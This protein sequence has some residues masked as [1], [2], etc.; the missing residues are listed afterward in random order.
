MGRIFAD[1]GYLKTDTSALHG[2][3]LGL[4]VAEA[5]IALSRDI[6]FPTTLAEVD[7][8]TAAHVERC[9]A[10]AKDPRLAVKLANMPVPLSA[11]TVDTYMHPILEAAATGDF[12]RIRNMP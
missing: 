9:L 1:A 11:E 4:A 8:F 2:R 12:T 5:M 3:E 7:G 10:A 6:G